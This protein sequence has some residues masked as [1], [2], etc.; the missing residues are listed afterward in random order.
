MDIRA[1]EKIVY[2]ANHLY[3]AYEVM[4]IYI[5][6]AYFNGKSINGYTTE[7]APIFFSNLVGGYMP[8]KPAS[9]K[10]RCIAFKTIAYTGNLVYSSA[11]ALPGNYQ[12]VS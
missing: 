9:T 3:T 12:F 1:Y 4:N 2:V 11:P 7:S 5:P 8:G 6:E 10:N